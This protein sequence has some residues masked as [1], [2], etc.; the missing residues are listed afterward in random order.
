MMRRTNRAG[1]TLVELLVVVLILAILTTIAVRGMEGLHD[2]SRFDGTR[3]GLA[4]LDDAIVGPAGRSRPDG[5]PLIT[6]F[7]ADMGRLPIAVAGEP[8]QEL[9]VKPAA[10]TPLSILAAPSD[11]EVLVE[12]GWRGPYLRLGAG[13]AS[14]RDGW[15]N[16]FLARTPA[17]AI[18]AVGAPIA[19]VA[20]QGADNAAGGTEYDADLDVRFEQVGVLP[21]RWT[22]NLVVEVVVFSASSPGPSTNPSPADGAVEIKYFGPNGVGGVAELTS[23]PLVPTGLAP[24][25]ATFAGVPIGPRVV[26]AYQGTLPTVY[27][28]LPIRVAVPP[29]GTVQRVVI[30]KP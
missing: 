14:L 29:G 24:V 8:L 16:P 12:T 2:Q 25:T 17:G 30:L 19:Q 15:G 23:G 6:G 26:R 3:Q 13:S 22:G 28:S 11:A 20:S 10:A 18:A 21:T 1:F 5:T 27:K 7:V 9:W 4:E